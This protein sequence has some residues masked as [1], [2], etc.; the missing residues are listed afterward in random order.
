M[1]NS[2]ITRGDFILMAL[3]VNIRDLINGRTV[4]WERIEFKR[5][6][7]QGPDNT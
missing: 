7:N 5:G 3:P 4:E 2:S 1:G 6:W